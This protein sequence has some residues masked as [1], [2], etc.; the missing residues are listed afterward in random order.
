MTATEAMEWIAA[1]GP[2]RRGQ[3]Y[4]REVVRAL[5]SYVRA[6]RNRGVT[7]QQLEVEVGLSVAPLRRWAAAAVDGDDAGG[8]AA[9]IRPVRIVVR[10]QE[11]V[12]PSSESLRL[13]LPGGA[14]VDGLRVADV[15]A[16]LG[17]LSA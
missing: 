6:E 1:H 7:W 15:L 17:G 13:T 5:G 11:P 8:R 9:M 4:P 2:V 10:D 3:R 14:V 12:A 16:L